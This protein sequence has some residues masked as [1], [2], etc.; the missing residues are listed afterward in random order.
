[1]CACK[2]ETRIMVHALTHPKTIMTKRIRRI[3]GRSLTT[4]STALHQRKERRLKKG[5][6]R[7]KYAHNAPCHCFPFVFVS[8]RYLFYIFCQ[9]PLALYTKASFA[10]MKQNIISFLSFCFYFER[11]KVDTLPFMASLFF[12]SLVR[13]QHPI[14]SYFK[15][16]KKVKWE[17]ENCS[18]SNIVSF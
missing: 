7:E 11:C 13:F 8:D 4:T 3:N 9:P 16:A 17:K 18:N 14:R 6:W 12:I 5:Q 10:A 1:M 15:K 2:P